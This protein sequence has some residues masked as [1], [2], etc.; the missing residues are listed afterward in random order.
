MPAKLLVSTLF[1]SQQT[2]QC[3]LHSDAERQRA[4]PYKTTKRLTSSSSVFSATCVT[5]HLSCDQSPPLCSGEFSD[6][7]SRHRTRIEKPPFPWIIIHFKHCYSGLVTHFS[8]MRKTKLP[9]SSSMCP[10]VPH[11]CCPASCASSLGAQ[12][13]LV[14]D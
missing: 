12:Q 1:N 5:V 7:L 13:H 10:L 9:Y 14:V 4:R 8:N 2:G 6:S 3:E 11:S